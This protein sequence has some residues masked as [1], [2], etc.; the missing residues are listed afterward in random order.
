MS[1]ARRIVLVGA[2]GLVG[3]AVLDAARGAPDLA[4]M[5][6][7]RREIALP[8]GGRAR[9]EMVLAPP[10]QWPRLIALTGPEA[11]ICALGTTRAR[12]GIEGLARIDR[13]LVLTVA[14]AA[15]KVGS[16]HFVCVTSVGADP[17]SRWPYLAIKGETEQA[18]GAMGFARLDLLRPGLLL[19]RREGEARPLEWAGQLASR[20][21]W[22]LL[23]SGLRRYRGIEAWQV[24][25]AALQAARAC[26]PGV[27]VH[28][29]E[30][31]VRLAACWQ[32]GQG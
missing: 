6:L 30:A 12:A 4:L 9:L 2:T 24:A 11:I 31:L 18:L 27:F 26:A 23:Q 25:R 1:E 3:R 16:R 14:E 7:A 20:M 10:D 17:A 15:R 13:D 19:G 28:E 21:A 8:R 29:N 32:E 5:A 22:P